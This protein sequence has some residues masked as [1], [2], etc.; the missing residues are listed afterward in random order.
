MSEISGGSEGDR[1]E[2][3]QP[4]DGS[5][6]GS[7]EALA[8]AMSPQ[9]SPLA[10]QSAAGVEADPADV[11]EQRAEVPVTDAVLHDTDTAGEASG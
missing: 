8:E 10:D 11:A 1:I 6:S 7:A 2:Q 9:L 3:A 5:A 4:V